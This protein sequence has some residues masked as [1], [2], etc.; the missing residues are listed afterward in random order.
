M[1]EKA[2]AIQS[3]FLDYTIKM[4]SPEMIVPSDTPKDK[5]A[6][7]DALKRNREEIQRLAS[8]LDITDICTSAPFP[9]LGEFT[10]LEWAVFVVC[11][12]T[13][14]I[15]QMKNIQTKLAALSGKRC[16]PCTAAIVM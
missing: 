13:R 15:R 3:M 10:R 5:A 1:Y 4:K 2:P 8:E 7:L 6:L 9:V 14:H 12:A 11:H 16:S